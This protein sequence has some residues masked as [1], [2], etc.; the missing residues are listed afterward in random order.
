MTMKARD[1]QEECCER[2]LAA[3]AQGYKAI[4]AVL[5]TGAGKTVVFSLLAR[6]CSNSKVL[7]IAPLRELVWQ[8]ADTA[9]RVTGERAGV[10]MADQWASWF[11]HRV[12]VAC[13][14][15]LLAGKTKRYKR[16]LGHR[17]II[18]DEAHTQFSPAVLEML[19]E[20]QEHG[21]IV[22]GFTATPFRMDGKRLMDFYETVAFEY[23]LKRGIED[24]W[25][26][27]PKAKTVRVESL[28]MSAVRVTGGDYAAGDLDLVLGASRQLH[29]MCLIVQKERVGSALAFLPGV[30][31][32]KALAELAE[33]AYGMRAAFIVG[34]TA[35]QPDEERA[36]IIN[37]YRAGEI[38]LL[39][40][41]QIAT[42]GFD[43]PVTRTIFM[44]RPTKSRVL[45]K[46]VIG[47]A[48][49]PAPGDVDGREELTAPGIEGVAA[50]MLSIASGTKPW[51]KVVDITGSVEN[52]SIVTAVDMFAKDDED[53]EVVARARQA[54]AENED[55]ESPEDLLAQAA[56]DVR[57]A[58]LIEEGLRAMKGQATGRLH[59]QD[60]EIGR[61]KCI[62]EYRCPLRGRMAGRTMGELDDGY[63]DWALRQRGLKG[64]QRSF[65]QREKA[66]RRSAAGHPG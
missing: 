2:I 18:V 61:K 9:D 16:F 35:I 36:M 6:M 29:Q 23:D 30:R 17:L 44:F 47:R 49:R 38:D 32:A 26:L 33:S 5:F 42:M 15:S 13:V 25:C 12:T 21:G 10:E 51:F 37:R 22:I 3:I 1:Y 58:K 55:A 60:V 40:N 46:Q 66:R 48:T 62:S 53:G 24:A 11:G 57:K 20:F 19:R 27:A 63:I 56:E 14:K 59:G 52:Q 64:W 43:A 8:C 65:F 34:N 45:F 31:S 54:A 50:R 41:C 28:D 7:V 4:L 39:C